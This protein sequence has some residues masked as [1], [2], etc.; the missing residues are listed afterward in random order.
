MK[1]EQK[2]FFESIINS[3]AP[4]VTLND[5]L[6]ALR[7]AEEII[8]KINESLNIILINDSKNSTSF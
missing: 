5:G 7:V 1:T 4:A 2:R 3:I 6:K 8:K